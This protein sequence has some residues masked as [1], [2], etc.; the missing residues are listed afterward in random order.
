MLRV[1]TKRRARALQILYAL[2]TAHRG[3]IA[4]AATGLARLT[5]PEPG[6]LED[7]EQLAR[8]VVLRQEEIDVLARGAADNWRFER[9]ASVERNILRL[10]IGELL[11]Q[12]APP[13]VIID[14]ALWL[15][16]RFAGD[17]A[18]AFINGVLDRVARDAG[19][20]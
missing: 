12:S 16:H 6:I 11:L 2:E 7:A 8:E 3:S 10:A 1:E 13:R 20:L 15:A 5:G 18:P 9:I 4:D 14:E 19:R 17:R